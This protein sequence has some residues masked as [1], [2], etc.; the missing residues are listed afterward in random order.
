MYWQP[1]WAPE[2]GT[3]SQ[4]QS[5]NERQQRVIDFGSC[6]LHNPRA[7]LRLVPIIGVLGSC[8]VNMV[9]IDVV[10]PKNACQQCINRAQT[11]RQQLRVLQLV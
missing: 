1:L 2:N 3:W 4:P 8:I 10:T 9:N 7:V 5:E 11:E 6:I